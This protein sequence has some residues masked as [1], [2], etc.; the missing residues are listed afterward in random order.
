MQI[1]GDTPQPFV[2]IGTTISHTLLPPLQQSISSTS[3]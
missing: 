3:I 2:P 1:E